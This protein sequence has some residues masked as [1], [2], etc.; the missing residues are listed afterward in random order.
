MNDPISCD[1][2]WIKFIKN[3][4]DE[5]GFGWVWSADDIDVKSFKSM[6]KQRCSDIFIQNWEADL[7]S[8]SQC[9]VYKLF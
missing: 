1:F 7:N 3:N 5:C 6:F 4:L 8:N 9:N 2:K